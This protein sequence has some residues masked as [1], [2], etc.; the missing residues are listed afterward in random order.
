MWNEN[1]S[2][3]KFL[4]SK[5]FN[6]AGNGVDRSILM[7]ACQYGFEE[8]V[9][10]LVDAGAPLEDTDEENWTPLSIASFAILHTD[11]PKAKRIQELLWKA[12][13]RTV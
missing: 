1:Y 4:M 6:L 11:L 3:M 5:G 10:M 13:A 7:D 8:A 2:L 9:K 12:G